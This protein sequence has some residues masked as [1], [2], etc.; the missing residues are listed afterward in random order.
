MIRGLLFDINGTVTDILTNEADD[1]LYRVT[2]N[3]LDYYGIHVSPW[4]LKED[5]FELNRKQRHESLEKFP[6]FD[7]AKIFLELIQRYQTYEVY[8]PETLAK[9]AANVFRA[10]SRFHLEPYSHVTDVLDAL[11]PHYQM[12]ALSDGQTLWAMPELRSVGLD[13][14]FSS[15]LVSGDVGFRKPEPRFFNMAL[16][17]MGLAPSEVIFIGNDMYRDV[18]GAKQLGM[19][20][21]F[22]R[23]NQGD[24]D[25]HGADPDYIIYQFSELPRAIEFLSK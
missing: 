4:Q 6:E 3:F 14:Y 20:T 18:Y 22:F 1:Q 11:K 9:H 8:E 10:A 13:R 2:S 15:V 25:Y 17:Q 19:K 12:A 16:A 24:H 23:S 21:V 7:V 5:Y